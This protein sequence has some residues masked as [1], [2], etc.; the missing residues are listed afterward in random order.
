MELLVENKIRETIGTARN[1]RTHYNVPSLTLEKAQH[2]S[3]QSNAFN[4]IIFI[5]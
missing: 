3:I 1:I 2:Y 5:F 4:L